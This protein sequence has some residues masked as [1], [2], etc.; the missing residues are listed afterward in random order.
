LKTV[1]FNEDY[2]HLQGANEIGELNFTLSRKFQV[3]KTLENSVL[4]LEIVCLET[5]RGCD[6]GSKRVRILAVFFV[7]FRI[8]S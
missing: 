3:E 5:S 8:I 2:L 4:F 6:L 1:V 7:G